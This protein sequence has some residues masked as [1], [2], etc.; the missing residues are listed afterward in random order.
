MV[1]RCRVLT[2]TSKSA[3][4]EQTLE[5][6]ENGGSTKVGHGM[7]EEGVTAARLIRKHM[8]PYPWSLHWVI[9]RPGWREVKKQFSSRIG[10][11]STFIMET[12]RSNG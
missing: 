10:T 4:S 8:C 9:M 11:V 12:G 2:L 6:G 1:A 7:G 5:V 3:T